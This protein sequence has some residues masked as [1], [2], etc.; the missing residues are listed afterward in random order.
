ML[1]YYEARQSFKVSGCEVFQGAMQYVL[2]HP[3]HCALD[4]QKVISR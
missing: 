4:I 2:C 1:T 3:P